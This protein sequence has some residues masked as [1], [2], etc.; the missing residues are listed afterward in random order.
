M[1]DGPLKQGL[2]YKSIRAKTAAASKNTCVCNY[3]KILLVKI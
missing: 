1:F 2:F 3:K